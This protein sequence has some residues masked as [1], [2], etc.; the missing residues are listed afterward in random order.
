M[1][2]KN[3]LTILKETFTLDEA[4]QYTGFKKSYLYKLCSQK[5]IPHYKSPGGRKTFFDRQKLDVW[6]KAVEIKTQSQVREELNT[7]INKLK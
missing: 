2:T 5:K 6:L 1:N 3:T 4:S 7:I